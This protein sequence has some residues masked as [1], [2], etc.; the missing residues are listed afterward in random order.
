MDLGDHQLDQLLQRLESRTELDLKRDI[1]TAASHFGR[2][3]HLPWMPS[4]GAVKNGDDAAALLQPDGSYLLLATDGMRAEFVQ[5]DPW[6]AGYSAVMVNISD[7]AAM[8]GKPLA[9]VDVIY[10]GDSASERVWQG[11]QAASSSFGV[12]VVGGHTCRTRGPTLVSCAIVGRALALLES[13]AAKV[14]QELL[15]AVDL[16]GVFRSVIAFN[17]ATT[18]SE[19]ELRQA[20]GLLSELAEAGCVSAAKDVSN[21]GLLGTLTMLLESSAVGATIDLAA[22]P[23]PEGVDAARWLMAF[24][25]YAFVLSTDPDKSQTV[26]RRFHALG[27]SC[28]RIGKVESALRLMVRSGAHSHAFADIR[29]PFTGFGSHVTASAS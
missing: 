27:I 20:A 4:A 1:Q 16:R 21:A 24:P 29:L 28:E 6:F 11:M 26:R 13:D 9:I 19:R 2:A 8:G 10:V 12:P 7:I 18:K 3:P 17:A 23:A 15:Y 5:H 22:V 25:S 14:G